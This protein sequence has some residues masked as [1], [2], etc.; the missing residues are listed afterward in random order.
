MGI[1]IL[2]GAGGGGPSDEVTATRAEVLS[3]VTAITSD[4]DDEPVEGTLVRRGNY[5]APVSIATGGNSIYVRIQNGGYIRED[6]YPEIVIPKTDFGNAVASD[7]LSGKTFT[8]ADGLAV[9][10]NIASQAGGTYNPTTSQRTLATGGK[11]L[12]SDVKVNG[13]ALPTASKLIKGYTYSLY[14]QSVAGTLTKDYD[15]IKGSKALVS[16]SNYTSAQG[17]FVAVGIG[18][19]AYSTA[20]VDLT[21]YKHLKLFCAGAQYNNAGDVFYTSNHVYYT[22][23][24]GTTTSTFTKSASHNGYSVG[25]LDVSS[26]TGSYYILIEPTASSPYS[27]AF[28]LVYDC[29]LTMS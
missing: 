5:T 19:I 27:G 22:F 6:G 24:I 2:M 23:G 8:G 21:N 29:Y 14:G 16:F 7:V 15:L 10:G 18:K 3:G 26:Y 25:V 9:T 28:G 1:A 13:F 17:S 11:Y 4:S 20:K 12:T